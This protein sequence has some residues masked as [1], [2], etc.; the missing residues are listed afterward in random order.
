MEVM[1]KEN[2]LEMRMCKKV[3]ETEEDGDDGAEDGT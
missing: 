2:R 1:R 3:E